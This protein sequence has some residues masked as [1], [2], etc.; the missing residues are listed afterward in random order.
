MINSFE[1]IVNK[2]CKVLKLTWE[3]ILVILMR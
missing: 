3:D 1:P 2:D